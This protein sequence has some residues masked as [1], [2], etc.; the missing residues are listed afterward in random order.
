[1]ALETEYKHLEARPGSSYRQLFV[2]G[3]GI[4]AD[5]LYR[6]TINAEPRTPQEVAADYDVPLQAVLEAIDYCKR[7]PDV[8]AADFQM[9][10]ES[11]RKYRLDKPSCVPPS[12]Q[13]DA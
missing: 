13:T 5:T 2:R 9:E 8:L 10:E 4:R 1:M 6:Q 7:N 3:R 11:I 12:S